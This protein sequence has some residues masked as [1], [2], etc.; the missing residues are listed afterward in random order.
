MM[1]SWL[2]PCFFTSI[3]VWIYSDYDIIYDHAWFQVYCDT[4]SKHAI[5]HTL[6]YLR[7]LQMI[8]IQDSMIS[9]EVSYL[10]DTFS[11]L[12]WSVFMP[13]HWIGKLF[14]AFLSQ[15]IILH[16]YWC[17]KTELSGKKF[18]QREAFVTC[19]TPIASWFW[20]G[21]HLHMLSKN[22]TTKFLSSISWRSGGPQQ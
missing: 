18:H 3:H 12:Y 1:S 8:I 6:W 16:I 14:H 15:Y 11:I 2:L 7:W 20:S 21:M 19:I 22:F 13:N 5:Y 10:A 9:M 4:I 17:Q